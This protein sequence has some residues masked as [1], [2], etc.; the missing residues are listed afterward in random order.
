MNHEETD[1]LAEVSRKTAPVMELHAE[2]TAAATAST[3]YYGQMQTDHDTR[4]ALWAGQQKDGRLPQKN[5]DGT[6]P[7]P[8]PR[9]SDLRIR[10]ADAVIRDHTA[11]KMAAFDGMR[12][13]TVARRADAGPASRAASTLL[14]YV[15]RTW[16][17]DETRRETRLLVSWAETYGYAFLATDWV[18]Q[19]RTVWQKVSAA[20]IAETAMN[21]LQGGQG[22]VEA[23][24]AGL[25]K[26]LDPTAEEEVAEG[27]FVA[28]GGAMSLAD[29]RRAAQRLREGQE[30][31]YP[32]V[33][34][35]G[36]PQWRA[37]MPWR[38]VLFPIDTRI[39]TEEARWFCVR[40]WFTEHELKERAGMDE[41]AADWL[42]KVLE[43]GGSE[44][45]DTAT[46]KDAVA[47]TSGALTGRRGMGVGGQAARYFEV[48]TVYYKALDKETGVPMTFRTVMS[49][50][51]EELQAAHGPFDYPGGEYPLTVMTREVVESA[52]V[53]SRSTADLALNWQQAIKSLQDARVNHADLT[54]LPP[55]RVPMYRAETP[56]VF[57][58]GM[59]VPT[60]DKGEIGVLDFAG[61]SR[62][63]MEVEAQ[64]RAEMDRY[65]GASADGV[66]PALFQ[67]LVGDRVSLFLDQLLSA[68]RKTLRLCQ[69]R[70]EPLVLTRITGGAP[71]T[72]QITREDLAGDYDMELTYDARVL[73][74]EF[75]Q[76]K[77]ESLK[78]LV[79]AA[80]T[81][82]A[83]DVS[84]YLGLAA[85]T[86]D[87]SLSGLLL[88]SPEKA[89][90]AE[91]NAAKQ[92]LS[93]I[94]NGIEPDLNVKGDSRLRLQT[95]QQLVTTSPTIAARLQQDEGARALFEN[96][97]KRHLFELTQQENALTGQIG[98]KATQSASALAMPPTGLPGAASG[99][100]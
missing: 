80:D 17:R 7:K 76:A 56:L 62:G 21:N 73:D 19:R 26:L 63:S 3:P 69:Q 99:I 12:F 47:V 79:L 71:E 59:T 65:F 95:M 5:S 81:I 52:I 33:I 90:E 64:L 40:S 14:D 30:V 74:P 25:E 45:L 15:L 18:E 94:L 60:V 9:A 44:R 2:V 78:N 50:E 8:W 28:A 77:L 88:R 20:K 96:T 92:D 32:R 55:L 46:V 39:S 51:V 72:L 16:L 11:Q 48:W 75:A 13:Q 66:S 87:P 61:E 100:K 35:E 86:I 41:W 67:L 24:M 22:D 37:L 27:L 54:I 29:A 43:R 91:V 98:V 85:N 82:G 10:A 6:R 58:P 70:M 93:L 49:P 1:P 84:S 68:V 97:M 36:R 31:L 89:Q 83:G 38:D 23:V 34:T 57:G 42:E 4:Y 53:D